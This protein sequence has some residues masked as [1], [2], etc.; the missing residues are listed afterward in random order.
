MNEEPEAK[1]FYVSSFSTTERLPPFVG[2]ERHKCSIVPLEMPKLIYFAL[3]AERFPTTIE[4][5]HVSPYETIL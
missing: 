1:I 5:N 3:M 2:M 4:L